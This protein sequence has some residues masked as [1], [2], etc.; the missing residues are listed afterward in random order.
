MTMPAPFIQGG[1]LHRA[2]EALQEEVIEAYRE[3]STGL[4]VGRR[5]EAQA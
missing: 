5:T 2:A 1:S 3:S 4:T